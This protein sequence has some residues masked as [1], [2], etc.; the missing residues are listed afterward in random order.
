MVIK[1]LRDLDPWEES[2]SH[3]YEVRRDLRGISSLELGFDVRPVTASPKCTRSLGGFL[4]YTRRASM[5]W[6]R[7]IDMSAYRVQLL[8]NCAW[9]LQVI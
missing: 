9:I 1:H 3:L 4:E 8:D 5:A 6:Y 2:G 7:G